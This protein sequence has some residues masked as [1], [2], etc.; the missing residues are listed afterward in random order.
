[1]QKITNQKSS[2]QKMVFMHLRK[3]GYRIT[4][5]GKILLLILQKIIRQNNS[6]LLRNQNIFID[7]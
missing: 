1:M 3:Y 6:F 2:L 5:I 4:K 7:L